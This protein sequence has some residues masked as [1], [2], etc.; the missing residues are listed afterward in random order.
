M[1]PLEPYRRALSYTYAPGMFPTMEA[2]KNRPLQVSRVLV[3]G[4]I[5]EENLQTLT[6][7]CVPHGIRTEQADRVLSRISGKDNCFAAAVVEKL[8]PPLGEDRC[9]LVLHQ[10]ADKGNLGTMLRSALGFS[11]VDIAV[12]RPA[13]DLYDPHVVRAS[14]G[15]MFSLNVAEYDDF[16]TYQKDFPHHHLYPFMLDGSVSL[17]EAAR[18]VQS[19]YALIMGNE[20]TGLPKAFQH[21]GT[22]VRIQHSDAI[23]SLNLSV[24]A[25]IGMHAFYQATHTL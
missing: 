17:R 13:A 19:P 22:P 3:S 18:Q 9:H 11:F 16:S 5:S 21:L 7:L 10:P 23:D 12:I 15:A 2:L 4:K 6:A 20:G 14:M 24:A 1:P 8:S 25:S